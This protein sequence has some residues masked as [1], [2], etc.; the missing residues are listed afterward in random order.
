LMVEKTVEDKSS[1]TIRKY[2]EDTLFVGGTDVGSVLGL[3]SQVWSRKF[4]VSKLGDP[5]C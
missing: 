1:S 3:V 2:K 5:V 4:S